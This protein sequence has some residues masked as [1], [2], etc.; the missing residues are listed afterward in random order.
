MLKK[1]FKNPLHP[2]KTKEYRPKQQKTN[3]LWQKPNKKNK[4]PSGVKIEALK[5][6][7]CLKNK[8]QF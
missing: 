5:R 3:H 2:F 6:L 4:T 7:D 8:L 1:F